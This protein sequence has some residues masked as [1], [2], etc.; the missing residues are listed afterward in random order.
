MSHV[1][2]YPLRKKY[3]FYFLA[4]LGLHCCS[5]AFFSCSKRRL[6][7]SYGE[8]AS[9]CSGFSFFGRTWAP[10]AQASVVSAHGLQSAGLLVLEHCSVTLQQMRSSQ[11]RYWTTV[12]CIAMW[13]LNHCTTREAPLSAFKASKYGLWIYLGQG[14]KSGL[15]TS[16]VTMRIRLSKSQHL[17]LYDGG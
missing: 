3:L 14:L 6:L 10:K 1:I 5:W 17:H 16:T 12:P 2:C 7:C 4:I 11:I 9:H 13:V 15:L 8:R